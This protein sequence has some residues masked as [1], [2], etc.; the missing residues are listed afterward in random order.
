MTDVWRDI[1]QNLSGVNAR[2]TNLQ[3]LL[4]ET[5]PQLITAWADINTACQR[6]MDSI[7]TGRAKLEA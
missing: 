4:D 7:I 3:L 6:S 2:D 5:R 1:A